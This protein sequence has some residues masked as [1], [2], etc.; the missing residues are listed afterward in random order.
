MLENTLVK[1]VQD[2]WCKGEGDVCERESFSE[3]LVYPGDFV[4][5]AIV[6]EFILGSCLFP[7]PNNTQRPIGSAQ[8]IR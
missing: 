6:V 4:F 1:L 7:I 8:G 5:H 2:V 3:R